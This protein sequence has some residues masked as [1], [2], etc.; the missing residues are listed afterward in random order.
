[1]GLL[2]CLSILTVDA[3]ERSSWG[4]FLPE[5]AKA[6]PK[7]PA[8]HPCKLQP[9]NSPKP[10]TPPRAR[11]PPRARHLILS[12]AAP[13]VALAANHFSSFAPPPFTIT[14]TT[15]PVAAAIHRIAWL[16]FGCNQSFKRC[17]LAQLPVSHLRVPLRSPLSLLG[18]A[19]VR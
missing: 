18:I 17:C 9:T 2:F 14:T 5:D 7:S 6:C 1:M 12:A 10:Q 11:A 8:K 19:R 16:A 15:F 13:N 3:I 4:C